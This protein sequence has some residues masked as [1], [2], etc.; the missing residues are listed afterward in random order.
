MMRAMLLSAAALTAGMT[1]GAP[2]SADPERP[3]QNP[4]P[5]SQYPAPAS[6]HAE[7]VPDP[8]EVQAIHNFGAC[9]ADTTP[10][11]ARRVLALDFRT[12]Q[13]KK[14]LRTLVYG[15]D[16]SR[17]LLGGW[18]YKFA[19]SLLAGAMAE[20]LLK[21]DIKKEELPKRLAYD[22]ARAPIQARNA[23]EKMALCTVMQAPEATM[24]LF[25]TEPATGGEQA[26]MKPVGDAL[27]NCLQKGTQVTLNGPGVRS[28]LALAAWR[29]ATTPEKAAP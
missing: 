11:G 13:Y 26:A 29:V 21:S 9:I 22:P 6:R 16:D 24:S 14:S 4:A 27:S 5:A 17:C 2:S 25:D 8:F 1:L 3:V 12:S 19:P 20:A 28:L 18:R 23:L 7:Y 15:H 10:E